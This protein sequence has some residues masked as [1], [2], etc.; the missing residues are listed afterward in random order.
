VLHLEDAGSG[1]NSSSPFGARFSPEEEEEFQALSRSEGL[2]E[3]FAASV[4]PSIFGSVGRCKIT[5]FEILWSRTL[6]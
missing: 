3:R 1:S 6:D 5:F 2:Y 4:A